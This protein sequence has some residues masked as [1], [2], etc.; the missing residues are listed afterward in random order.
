MIWFFIN[1]NISTR[2]EKACILAE[3]LGHYHTTS[4]NILDKQKFVNFS[5]YFVM[6]DYIKSLLCQ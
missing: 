1:Q 5:F 2:S 6:F 4:V 3:E